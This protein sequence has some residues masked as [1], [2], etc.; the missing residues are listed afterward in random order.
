[1][2]YYKYYSIIIYKCWW[3][4]K[5]WIGISFF[6][7]TIYSVIRLGKLGLVYRFFLTISI[8]ANPIEHI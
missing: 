2:N 6:S 8:N 5:V 7:Y 4:R 3:V 1:M